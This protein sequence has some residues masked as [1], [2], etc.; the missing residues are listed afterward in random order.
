LNFSKRAFTSN[1]AV[2]ILLANLSELV[3]AQEF[4]EEMWKKMLSSPD[5]M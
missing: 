2:S 4:D 5:T 3:S 1:K